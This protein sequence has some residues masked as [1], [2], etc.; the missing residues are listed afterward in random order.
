MDEDLLATRV[1]QLEGALREA[2]LY[3]PAGAQR[4]RLLTVLDPFTDPERLVARCYG[5]RVDEPF[6]LPEA[7]Q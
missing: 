3:V 4:E 7:P 6:P 5:A 1:K 2:V